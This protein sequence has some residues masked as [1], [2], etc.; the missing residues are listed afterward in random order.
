MRTRLLRFQQAV[1]IA[2]F[3]GL[4]FLSALQVT[5][6]TSENRL[7]AQPEAARVLVVANRNS[8][9]SLRVAQYYMKRRNI[10]RTNFLTLNLPD[11]TLHFESI[12]Y[13]TYQNQ[14]EQPLRKFLARQKLTDSIRY[15][16]LTKG[17][18]LRIK[19]VPYP[20]S[21]GKTF[22]QDQSVDSTIA[23]MDYKISP[24]EFRDKSYT[25]SSGQ[26]VYGLLTPNLY[27]RQTIPFDH[28]LT[29]G[30]LVTRLDG[31]TEADARSLVDR[32][33]TPRPRLSGSVLIDPDEAHSVVITPNSANNGA[34]EPQVIDIFDPKDCTPQMMPHCTPNPVSLAESAGSRWELDINDDFQLTAQLMASTFP[35]LSMSIAPPNTFATGKDL[36]AYVSWGSNDSSFRVDN[37]HNL[38]FLPG[39]IAETI[40][41]T[42]ART[43]FP[44]WRGQSL[45]GDLVAGHQGVTGIRGYVD[46]PEN[47]GIGSPAVLFSN[48]LQ[49]A[50]LATA[51]YRSIRFV[52]WRDL[53]L[54]DPLATA[55]VDD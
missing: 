10:P 51:Y 9:V 2:L 48:Y 1:L 44:T 45:I 32:A 6:A 50:N 36:V 19:K 17:V 20:R 35:Q 28:R 27:W 41:S 42:S 11:S 55:L 46:E 29:G 24:I 5:Q 30:Y 4:S 15:I 22:A 38:T 3:I 12:A 53:V 49:G 37:Y 8:P 31:F 52:G 18:P 25:A 26:D 16:V 39:A 21:G 43:F 33:M 34:K 7:V 54:G 47:R 14:V 40:V 23:A 13:S